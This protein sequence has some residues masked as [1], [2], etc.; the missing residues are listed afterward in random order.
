MLNRYAK[1]IY[2]ETH[3]KISALGAVIGANVCLCETN[4]TD[5]IVF[6]AIIGAISGGLITLSA[7]FTI[8][9]LVLC[10]PSIIYRNLKST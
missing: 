3:F 7:P 8:P 5:G 4:N 9:V 10:T 2:S 1:F 6:P